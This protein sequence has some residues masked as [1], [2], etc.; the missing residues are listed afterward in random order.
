MLP[1][2][3]S[4]SSR[5]WSRS[6]GRVAKRAA[7][8]SSTASF[9]RRDTRR[10]LLAVQRGRSVQALQA[11]GLQYSGVRLIRRTNQPP[12]CPAAGSDFTHDAIV[13]LLQPTH[14]R[15]VARSKRLPSRTEIGIAVWVVAEL[16]LAEEAPAHR[17]ASLRARDIGDDP[18]LLAGFAILGLE[19]T[20]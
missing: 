11:S 7:T 3:C 14:M 10:A 18:G 8:R 2:G 15:A 17:W 19:V 1:N 6:S 13:D 16:V 20:P 4:T 9:S 12:L 5:R